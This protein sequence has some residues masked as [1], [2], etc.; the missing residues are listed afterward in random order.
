MR[1]RLSL[2][3]SSFSLSL[4]NERSSFTAPLN[5]EWEKLWRSCW[6]NNLFMAF[7]TAISNKVISPALSSVS[8]A[9]SMSSWWQNVDP[10][11]KDPILGVT[12]A[13]LADP[14]PD[15]V[16]VGVVSITV[17][18]FWGSDRLLAFVT[19]LCFWLD[20]ICLFSWKIK[21]RSRKSIRMLR[22]R[23]LEIKK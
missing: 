2:G 14:S 15:K 20:L 5:L 23:S 9:R 4:F 7:R 1:F 3:Y 6:R 18:F 21:T 22:K 11:P 17:H 16:N 12:E 8:G 10:A 13:F 19:L